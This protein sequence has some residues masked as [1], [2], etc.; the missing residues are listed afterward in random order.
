MFCISR[1]KRIVTLR[2]C[3]GVTPPA[4]AAL[5]ADFPSAKIAYDLAGSIYRL[6]L[7]IKYIAGAVAVG[8]SDSPSL[9][10][11]NH[12]SVITVTHQHYSSTK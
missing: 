1:G 6:L 4:V 10:V 5:D 8:A 7:R 12:V 2:N 9:R 3:I 11:V